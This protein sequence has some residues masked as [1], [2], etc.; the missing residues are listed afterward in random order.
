[1]HACIQLIAHAHTSELSVQICI[2]PSA[3]KGLGSLLAHGLSP[4]LSG[5]HLHARASLGEEAARTQ[6]VR[7]I[8]AAAIPPNDQPEAFGLNVICAIVFIC[9]AL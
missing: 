9:A 8:A 7:I 3:G 5:S 1:M 2:I 4:L 6:R